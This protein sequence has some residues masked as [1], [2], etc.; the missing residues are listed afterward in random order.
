[1][2]VRTR[3]ISPLAACLLLALPA[4]AQVGQLFDAPDFLTETVGG[5]VRAHGDFNNDGNE[6]LLHITNWLD[7]N[8]MKVLLGDGAGGFVAQAQHNWTVPFNVDYAKFEPSVGDFNGD[9]NLDVAVDRNAFLSPTNGLAIFFGDGAGGFASELLVP[10]GRSATSTHPGEVDGDPASELLVRF[11]NSSFQSFIAWL[12]WNG[13]SFQLSTPLPVGTPADAAGLFVETVGDFDGDGFDDVAGTSTTNF[14]QVRFF[15]TVGGSPTYGGSIPVPVSMQNINHRIK[16]GDADGDGDIDLLHLVFISGEP[17]PLI[18]AYENTGTSLFARPPESVPTPTTLWFQ[19]H[20]LV[21]GDWNGDGWLDL[22]SLSGNVDIIRSDADWTFSEG[23]ELFDISQVPGAGP[24]DVNGDGWMDFVGGHTLHLGD[25]T[26]GGAAP[27]LPGPAANYAGGFYALDF[28][29]DGDV[30]LTGGG[31]GGHDLNDGTGIFTLALGGPFPF[32]GFFPQPPAPHLYGEEV[33]FAD[34]TGDGR[35]DYLVKYKK[36]ISLFVVKFVEMRLLAADDLGRYSDLGPAAAPLLEIDRPLSG[37]NEHWATGDADGDGDLDLLVDG[38]YW[39]NTGAGFFDLFV[40]VGQGRIFGAADVDS[41]GDMDLLERLTSGSDSELR[42]LQKSSA[43]GYVPSVLGTVAGTA[44][45]RFID[46]DQDGDLD[47]A[48]ADAEESELLLVQNLGAAFGPAVLLDAVV[49]DLALLGIDDLD[50]DGLSD[51]LALRHVS[52]GFPFEITLLTEYHRTGPGL[53]YV[54][55]SEALPPS[56]VGF[57][58]DGFIDIDSDGDLDLL[59]SF[60]MLNQEAG[61]LTSGIT[62][63]FGSGSPGTSGVVPV[64]G[65]QGPPTSANPNLEIHLTQGVGSGLLFVALS[66][67]EVALPDVPLPGLTLYV[68]APSIAGPFGLGGQPSQPGVGSVALPLSA[69]PAL[70]GLEFIMQGFVFDG[71]A[72]AGVAATNGLRI[73]FGL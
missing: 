26:F 34:F 8:G 27:G 55:A 17:G 31:Q 13:T 9:G 32:I 57:G 3:S 45:A 36:T 73:T 19:P 69:S 41:D 66:P 28:E 23:T 62:Q 15:P 71:G 64:L 43:G 2:I 44:E 47:V 67:T 59:G 6:D 30:D 22:L 48:A 53:N 1:M 29:G 51:L 63:Q 20:N 5:E 38:G 61:P 42:L 39:R 72:P 7:W 4:A 10:L 35:R 60:I 21:L 24:L 18:R 56:G 25:G 37:S 12:D 14:D 70:T 16:A 49:P 33:A 40:A 58:V 54:L 50:A 52:D 11:T 68:G 46:I 65:A